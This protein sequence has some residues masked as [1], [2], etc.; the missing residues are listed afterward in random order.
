L[1]SLGGI[2]DVVVSIVSNQNL[3]KICTDTGIAHYINRNHS[4]PGEQSRRTTSATIEAI[5]AA[6]YLDSGKNI[7]EVRAAMTSLGL[8]APAATGTG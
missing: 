5:L 1:S 3:A 6:V 2:N 8:A 7:D 4:Q